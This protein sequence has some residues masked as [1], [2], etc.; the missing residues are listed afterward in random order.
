MRV[1]SPQ[2]NS[3]TL[4]IVYLFGKYLITLCVSKTV[5]H[6]MLHGCNFFCY[7]QFFSSADSLLLVENFKPWTSFL[8]EM[9]LS[10]FNHFFSLSCPHTLVSLFFSFR[11]S[12]LVP[13]G[14]ALYCWVP[15]GNR[16]YNHFFCVLTNYELIRR[17]DCFF[18]GVCAL[19][20]YNLFKFHLWL[21]MRKRINLSKAFENN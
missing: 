12:S 18:S 8:K 2:K 1:V 10:M 17:V 15:R 5:L 19:E 3:F 6:R 11:T 14:Y 9:G 7:I 13:R 4:L 21:V 20:K 16:F